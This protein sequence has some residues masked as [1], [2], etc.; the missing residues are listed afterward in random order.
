[1]LMQLVV[2]LVVFVVG[3]VAEYHFGLYER[4]VTILA[5]LAAVLRLALQIAAACL[6]AIWQWLARLPF[7]LLLIR[8]L[9]FAAAV[10]VLLFV[11][12][13]TQQLVW[14]DVPSVAPSRDAADWSMLG[15]IIAGVLALIAFL[16]TGVAALASGIW[17]VVSNITSGLVALAKWLLTILSALA[18]VMP[19]S[20]TQEPQAMV[21]PLTVVGTAHVA[22]K[23]EEYLIFHPL[24]GE[25]C[26]R[27]TRRAGHPLSLRQCI[28]LAQ[29]S[30]LQQ[31]VNKKGL[32]EAPRV[33][34]PD[35]FSL[36]D[37]KWSILR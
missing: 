17:L 11:A 3:V 14:M 5:R 26:I 1:M 8:V 37:D 24:P 10:A 34:L 6:Q 9:G 23:P 25:G 31:V 12:F 20:C 7:E 4:T 28:E 27:V 29:Q 16:V 18:L 33:Y 13:L 35:E 22:P 15:W 30:N 32:H 19:A 36:R 21:P 2:A